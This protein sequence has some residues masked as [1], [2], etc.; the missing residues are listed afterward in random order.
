MTNRQIEINRVNFPRMA[1][2]RCFV[3]PW[4]AR[5]SGGD[6]VTVDNRTNQSVTIFFPNGAALFQGTVAPV[7]QVVGANSQH[8]FTV[9]AAPPSGR[10]PYA[11]FCGAIKDFAEGNSSPSIEVP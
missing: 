9:V 4:A 8:Q 6:T 1:K 11:V 5:V 3:D 10:H 7:V 2:D